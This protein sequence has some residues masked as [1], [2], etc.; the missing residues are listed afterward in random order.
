M[1][2]TSQC[3]RFI[4]SPFYSAPREFPAQ[5]LPPPQVQAAAPAVPSLTPQQKAE[6]E[7]A[8]R[9]RQ[10]AADEAQARRAAQLAA[11]EHARFLARYLSTPFERKPGKTMLGIVVASDTGDANAECANALAARFNSGN[12]ETLPDLFSSAFVSDRLFTETLGGSTAVLN[13]LELAR[14]STHSCS[15]GKPFNI[16]PTPRSKRH[17]RHH[18]PRN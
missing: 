9:A 18:E 5:S 4:P 2:A 14:S 3:V 12:T 17:H 15:P 6:I 7:Y 8:A 1:A 11:E 13:K 16:L 10:T